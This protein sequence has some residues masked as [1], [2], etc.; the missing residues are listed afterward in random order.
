VPRWRRGAFAVVAL[1]ALVPGCGNGGGETAG[2]GGGASGSGTLAYALPGTVG[3]VDPLLADTRS[4]LIVTRQVHEPLVESLAG[5]FGDVRRARGLAIAWR[6][7]A[8]GEIWSFRLRDGIRFQDGT[9]LNAGA[10][11]ANVERWRT[12][13]VGRELLPELVAAD[14]PRPD[15]V[16]FILAVP[17]HNLPD[18]L[19]APR[20]GLVSPGAL[21]PHSGLAARLSRPD[22]SGTGPFELRERSRSGPIVL[23]RNTDWW[24]TRLDLGPVL[25]QV[26]FDVVPGRSER[27]AMLNQGTVQ[28]ADSLESDAIPELRRNPLLTYVEDHEVVLGMERSVRGVDSATTIEPLSDVWLTVVGGS[29]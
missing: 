28:V 27:L 29:D 23:A 20:L 21:R 18:R 1:L 5:P 8:N 4:E 6:S 25:D 3:E 12:L 17:V 16:R 10:V 14:A 13:P 2:P 19:S 22:R 24:G 9:P 26:E 7:T 15:L 11:L